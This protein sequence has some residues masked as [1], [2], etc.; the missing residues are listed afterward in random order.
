MRNFFIFC[1][2]LAA[3]F[4]VRSQFTLSG[5]YDSYVGV[6]KK[7]ISN[8][9]FMVSHSKIGTYDINLLEL[10]LRY[11][12]KAWTAQ[13]SPALG[14]YMQ[15]NYALEEPLRRYIY[16]GYLQYAKG[17]NELAVGTFSSPYTQETPRGVDQLSASRSLVSTTSGE[18]KFS[19][20]N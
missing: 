18:R 5:T 20:T 4:Q 17:K 16:E 13:F 19:R 15:N 10:E 12:R 11:T 6:S 8:L 9:P 7:G 3:V 1:F 2:F 14:S